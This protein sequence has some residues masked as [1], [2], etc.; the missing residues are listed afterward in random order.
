MNNTSTMNDYYNPS[1]FGCVAK[2]FSDTQSSGDYKSL[3]SVAGR[4]NSNNA[5][6]VKEPQV[7]LSSS[8]LCRR[9]KGGYA[10]CVRHNKNARTSK[11]N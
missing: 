10:R 4:H 8:H 7:I 5:G 1:S 2:L 9:K 6:M 3:A 11:D